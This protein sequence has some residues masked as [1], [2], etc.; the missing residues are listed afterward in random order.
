[1]KVVEGT[2]QYWYFFIRRRNA[3]SGHKLSAGLHLYYY[4]NKKG[5]RRRS[6]TFRL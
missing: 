6:D 4:I 5:A 3:R 2:T 1:M